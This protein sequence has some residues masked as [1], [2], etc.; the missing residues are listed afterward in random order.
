MTNLITFKSVIFILFFTLDY[1]RIQE[2]F[3]ILFERSGGFTGISR[4]TAIKS[5]SLTIEEQDELKRIIDEADFFNWVSSDAEQNKVTDQF[6]YS[7][8]IEYGVE[9]R[10]LILGESE[11]PDHF[12]PLITYLVTKTRTQK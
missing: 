9:K 12:R 4:S 10:E 8:T 11:I 3:S 2:P 7:I 1:V 5:D 6:R